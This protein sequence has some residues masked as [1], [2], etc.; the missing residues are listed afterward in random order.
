MPF[1]AKV[2][3][4]IEEFE[5]D[6]HEQARR[7]GILPDERP[8]FLDEQG[9]VGQNHD[10]HSE[11]FDAYD[12]TSVRCIKVSERVGSGNKRRSWLIGRGAHRL[13]WTELGVRV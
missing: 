12:R 5:L 10:V 13:P 11:N 9:V 3:D 8:V 7:G 1:Q 6:G 4:R 2:D